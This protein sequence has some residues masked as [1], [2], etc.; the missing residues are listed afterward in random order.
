M[1]GSTRTWKLFGI[2]TTKSCHLKVEDHMPLFVLVN[3][4]PFNKKKYE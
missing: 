4:T 3:K 2:S 1:V